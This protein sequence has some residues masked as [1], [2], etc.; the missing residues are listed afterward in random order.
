MAIILSFETTC[1][2]EA[3]A[4]DLIDVILDTELVKSMREIIAQREFKTL[5]DQTENEVFLQKVASD[6]ADLISR[7]P[8]M[9]E[10]QTTKG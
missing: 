3:I 6:F 2:L 1:H 5:V 7:R 4:T 8:L 10:H 9:L